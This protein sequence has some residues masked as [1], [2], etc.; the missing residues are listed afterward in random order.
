MT[1][2]CKI[3]YVFVCL[4]EITL[5]PKQEVEMMFLCVSVGPGL[6]GHGQR[7]KGQFPLNRD[8]YILCGFSSMLSFASPFFLR[9]TL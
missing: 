2:I 4:E 8:T 1:Y 3:G 5:G 6:Y 9:K 7:L